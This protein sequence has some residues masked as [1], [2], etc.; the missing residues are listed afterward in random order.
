AGRD[1]GNTRPTRR[2]GSLPST[3]PGGLGP[4]PRIPGT[5]RDA[6]SGCSPRGRGRWGLLGGHL[7]A[8]LQELGGPSRPSGLGRR[9]HPRAIVTVEVLVE[10]DEVAEVR[11]SIQSGVTTEDRTAPAAVAQE[12]ARQ[13][14]GDVGR[15]LLEGELLPRAGWVLH[16]EGVTEIVVE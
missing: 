12:D 2:S 6:P 11:V 10:G 15:N 8:L 14:P 1:V 13:A 7:V 16:G 9:A 3:R 4:H 5:R